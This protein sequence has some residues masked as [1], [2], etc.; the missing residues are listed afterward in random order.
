MTVDPDR[1]LEQE[2]IGRALQEPDAWQEF[3]DDYA[4]D[5]W[6]VCQQLCSENECNGTFIECWKALG[7]NDGATLRK[8]DGRSSLRTYLRQ[9]VV[10]ILAERL[11]EFLGN[12]PKRG[13]E[14]FERFFHREICGVIFRVAGTPQQLEKLGFS[15]EDVYQDVSLELAADGFRRLRAYDGRGSLTGFVRRV[16]RNLCLDWC[17]KHEGRRRI[18]VAISRLGEHGEQ[19]Y[20]WIFWEGRSAAEAEALLDGQVQPREAQEVVRRVQ[21]VGGP[22]MPPQRA[23]RRA[24]SLEEQQDVAAHAAQSPEKMLLENEKSSQR[25]RL[26]DCLQGIIVQLQTNEQLYIR[27]RFHEEPPLAPQEIARALSITASEV[28]RIRQYIVGRLREELSRLGFDLERVG[29][30]LE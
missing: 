26:L 6:A 17:R 5:V 9:A 23:E 18:P 19:V 4:A 20:R 10:D 16:V 12:D 14:A 24:L 7:A 8:F 29:E 15:K 21:E 27:F 13:W 2:R 1:K 22:L 28:Y 25:E 11:R 3:V 30:L